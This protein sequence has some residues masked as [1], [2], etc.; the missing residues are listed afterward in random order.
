MREKEQQ[1]LVRLALHIEL[2]GRGEITQ[3]T[4][5]RLAGKDG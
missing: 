4:S 2:D 3:D 1:L 5:H